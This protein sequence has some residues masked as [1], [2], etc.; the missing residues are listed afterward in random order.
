M[1]QMHYLVISLSCLLYFS[2]LSS[3]QDVDKKLEEIDAPIDKITI[4]SNGKDYTFEGEDAQ[5]L[6]RELKSTS[7]TSKSFVMKY[8]DDDADTKK[9]IIISSDGDEE[10]ID[11]TGDIDDEFIWLG[12]DDGDLDELEKRVKVEIEDGKKKVTVTKNENGEEKTEVY[13]GEEAAAYLEK[14]KSDSDN[15]FEF[16]LDDESGE[17]TKKIIIEKKK[18]DVE[19]E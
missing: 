19:S 3:G 17:K 7:N 10:V 15:F 16:K 12:D 1:K 9:I 13:E 8:D 5:N 4:T 6:F 14:M 2:P 11:I 18:V